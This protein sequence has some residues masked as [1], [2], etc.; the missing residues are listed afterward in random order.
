[1]AVGFHPIANLFQA[2]HRI[3]LKISGADDI[4]E[5]LFQ[6]GMYHLAS[7]DNNTVTVY[8]SAEYPS[9]VLLPIT[10]G[11]LGGI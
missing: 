1:M 6:I 10:R 8:H 2:G 5:N 4:P 11:N 3:L 9:H 7:Q